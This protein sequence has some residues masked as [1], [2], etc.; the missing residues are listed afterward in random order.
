MPSHMLV[1]SS[2][3]RAGARVQELL[4][5]W[6]HPVSREIVPVGRVSFNGTTYAF[7][8]TVAASRIDGFRA[9]SGLG[10]L[11]QHTE[12]AT[13]PAIFRQRVMDPA[14][15]DFAS[16]AQSLGLRESEATPWEQIVGSG[17]GRAGDTLQ[18]MT[19][20][21]V[22]N[23]H[24]RARFFANG[25]RHVPGRVALIGGREVLVSEDEHERALQS[26][27][28]GDS[29]GVVAEELNTV[30]QNA[31]LVMAGNTPL[32]W[33]PRLLAPAVRR[34]I[35]AVPLTLTVVRTN[36]PE[37]PSHLRLVLELEAVVPQDF[38]FDPAGNWNAL[39]S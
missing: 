24:A 17:G 21:V 25:V 37:S 20:P 38:A 27:L 1:E 35:G 34:L 31:T 12:S 10:P 4:V 7:D 26:L 36:G 9:L 14:R 23:G 18:F 8:Y 22:E 3:P 15:P 13:L 28:P 33:V 29:V 19:L 39:S 30:D 32:G 16:Y 6:Q 11:G 5:L 2:T